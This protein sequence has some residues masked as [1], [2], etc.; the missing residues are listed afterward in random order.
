M[1]ALISE[2]EKLQE[3]FYSRGFNEWASEAKDA[4][5]LLK[6]G[7]RSVVD[8]LCLKYA[9]TCEVENLFITEYE[10]AKESEV[11]ALNEEL[12][13]AI[14]AINLALEASQSANT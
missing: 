12:A 5:T 7:D 10:Q 13:N 9:P 8:R 4:I 1:V 14:N 11:V 6:R 3:Y 2:L